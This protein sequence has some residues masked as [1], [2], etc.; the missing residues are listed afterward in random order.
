MQHPKLR[1]LVERLEATLFRGMDPVK[2]VI[3]FNHRLSLSQVKEVLKRR[4]RI[5][6]RLAAVKPGSKDYK[7]RVAALRRSEDLVRRQSWFRLRKRLSQ[8]LEIEE[9]DRVELTLLRNVALVPSA[10]RG[11]LATFWIE[12]LTRLAQK[13]SDDMLS[14]GQLRREIR[15][16][17]EKPD[18]GAARRRL[19]RLR[20]RHFKP[21]EILDGSVGMAQRERLLT[22]FNSK[23]VPP[24]VLLVSQAGSEGQDMHR[25]C[26]DVIHYDLHWNPTVLH[27]RTGRVYRDMIDAKDIHVRRLDYQPGYD[28]RILEYAKNREAYQDFLLGEKK[29][30]EFLKAIGQDGFHA[31]SDAPIF[32][33]ARGWRM[34]LTPDPLRK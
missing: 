28:F 33:R 8:W 14:D 19:R 13:R 2:A 12:L 5:V 31:T 17:F 6:T 30:A 10:Q 11:L 3:F 25:A 22:W 20:I 1:L 32:K 21:V 24:Y 9:L 23:G 15:G 7:P 18:R 16:H 26:R 27:Q 34:D 4:M 29:L